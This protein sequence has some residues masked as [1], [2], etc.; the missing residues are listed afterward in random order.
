[1]MYQIIGF[2]GSGVQ[3]LVCC[4]HCL[5]LSIS[6]W[7]DTCVGKNQFCQPHWC[8]PWGPSDTYTYGP[9]IPSYYESLSLYNIYITYLTNMYTYIYTCY[10]C[11]IQYIHTYIYISLNPFKANFKGLF[12]PEG[13][14]EELMYVGLPS[15]QN[16][17]VHSQEPETSGI[18]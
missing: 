4:Q 18:S 9:Y 2:R 7:T 8:F 5:S 1:M 13:W 17:G 3:G 15:A 10:K 11:Y 14:I 16:L 12:G 6:G